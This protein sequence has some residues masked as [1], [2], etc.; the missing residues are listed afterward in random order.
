MFW[1]KN[2]CNCVLISCGIPTT[3]VV[4]NLLH[5]QEKLAR[6]A[7]TAVNQAFL[8]LYMQKMCIKEL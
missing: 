2:S 5:S 1:R 8:E 3:T 6:S 4:G 7:K